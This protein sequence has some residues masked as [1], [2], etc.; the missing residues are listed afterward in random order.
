[1]KLCLSHLLR[2]HIGAAMAASAAMAIGCDH[3]LRWA[4]SCPWAHAAQPP[5][6]NKPIRVVVPYGAGSSPDVIMRILTE[7]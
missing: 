1:M 3:R 5:W 6:P 2:Q 4:H 7:N